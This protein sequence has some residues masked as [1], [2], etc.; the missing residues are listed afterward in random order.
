MILGDGL[1]M[2]DHF[3]DDEIQELLCEG[4]VK[5]RVLGEAAQACD[6]GSFA[7]WIASREFVRGLQDANFLG[8]LEPLCEQED[9]GSVDVVNAGP[10]GQ[11]LIHDGA[12]HL[13]GQGTRSRVEGIGVFGK[14]IVLLG[15]AHQSMVWGGTDV[16]VT[17]RH[18]N[19]AGTASIVPPRTEQAALETVFVALESE[20]NGS[21]TA[22]SAK[23][24]P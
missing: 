12:V 23:E 24:L 17:W 9:E 11:Q 14:G 4:G 22:G 6:L 3:A 1:V 7:A 16:G 18:R 19:G 8:G 20:Q 5:M 15:H 21:I 10:D 13:A 2:A